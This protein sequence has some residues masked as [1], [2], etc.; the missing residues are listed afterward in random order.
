V[1]FS[2]RRQLWI[3]P[4]F[5][6][7][8]ENVGGLR[9]TEGPSLAE[10]YSKAGPFKSL[11]ITADPDLRQS[12]KTHRLGKSA[13]NWGLVCHC[14]GERTFQLAVI[15]VRA[16]GAS[17]PS[18]TSKIRAGRDLRRTR[19]WIANRET[20]GYSTKSRTRAASSR[21]RSQH[22]SQFPRQPEPRAAHAASAPIN[23]RHPR[24]LPEDAEALKQDV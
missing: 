7:F 2:G 9:Q 16:P 6:S 4:E 19:R 12:R 13:D 10:L 20:Y 17:S 22:K 14:C 11:D 15:C 21:R 18:P 3:P 5:D 24:M 23:R 8:C 1:C